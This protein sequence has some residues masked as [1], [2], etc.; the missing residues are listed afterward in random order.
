M[1]QMNRATITSVPVRGMREVRLL[2]LDLL[3]GFHEPYL[4][5]EI[6]RWRVINFNYAVQGLHV[7]HN[8][9][10]DDLRWLVCERKGSTL[11]VI[12]NKEGFVV[13]GLINTFRRLEDMG[14]LEEVA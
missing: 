2:P 10:S 12:Y 5:E 11:A 1:S 4:K 6:M 8:K 13:D 9:L 14:I 7:S 3:K